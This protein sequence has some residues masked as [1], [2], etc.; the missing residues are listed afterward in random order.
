[1][2]E[3]TIPGGR[4][5]GTPLAEASDSTLQY[6]ADHA[7]EDAMKDACIDE[8]ERRGVADAGE[9]PAEQ[10]PPRRERTRA[11]GE[12]QPPRREQQ[13]PRR[14]PR[15]NAPAPRSAIQ[16]YQG[17]HTDAKEATEALAKLQEVGHLVSPAPA[18]AQL[19]E[20]TALVVSAVAIDSARETYAIQGQERGLAK[21]ALY[22]I[23]GALGVSWSGQESGRLDDGSDPHFVH[24]RAVGYLRDFDGSLRQIKGEKIMDM[25][26]GSPQLQALQS[27]AEAKAKRTNQP[28]GDWQS[29]VRDTRLFIL[30][31]AESKA[32]ERAIRSLGI[33]TSYTAEELRKPFFGA[34]LQFT[35]HTDDP[36]LKHLFAAK[37]A[38]SFLGAQSQLYGKPMQRA[39][40]RGGAPPPVGRDYDRA[41]YDAETEG[42]E[43]PH[44]DD[45]VVDDGYDP[46]G[47]DG[48]KF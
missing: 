10:Q 39:E 6:W 24:F 29:Q 21:V 25:R 37:I 44:D 38:E 8:L 12:R 3:F 35:G 22:K 42:H 43:V 13:A 1:M 17:A 18:V 2:S 20:G 15:A 33:R 5:K 36:E 31:H 28:V 9:P 30:E 16:Q 14:S 7:R 19:P 46:T 23:A 4:E 45:G 34:R 47:T 48:N 32:Q 40:Q 41:G 27:R 11:E 26:E